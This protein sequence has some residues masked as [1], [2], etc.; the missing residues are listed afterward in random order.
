[1]RGKPCPSHAPNGVTMALPHEAE[2][3]F[4]PPAAPPPPPLNTPQTPDIGEV[5]TE[6]LSHYL[7]DLDGEA[8]APLYDMVLRQVEP[9]LLVFALTHA[10][11]NQSVAARLLGINRNTLRRKLA[12]YGLIGKAA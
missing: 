9:P 8:P 7:A 3:V 5:L 12:D 4:S 10:Q 2:A 6:A 11:G 1:M